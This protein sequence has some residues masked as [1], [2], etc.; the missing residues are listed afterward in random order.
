[1][2]ADTTAAPRAPVRKK[3]FDGAERGRLRAA[4]LRYMEAH[5]IGVPTL[6]V[7][8]AESANRSQDLIPLKTL[9]RF[10]AGT[11]RTNDAILVPCHQFASAL[12]DYGGAEE[13]GPDM[14]SRALREFFSLPEPG[15]LMT[16]VLSNAYAVFTNPGGAGLRQFR[17]DD[18]T[19]EVPYSEFALPAAPEGPC[20]PVKEQVFNPARRHP[21]RPDDGRVC[22]RYEGVLVHFGNEIFVLLKNVLTRLPKTY[23]LWRNE[24]LLEGFRFEPP[25][26]PGSDVTR[27]PERFVF[28]PRRQ[29]SSAS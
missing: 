4:L 16:P 25:F 24:R 19:F 3:S 13:G 26:T 7:R 15:T 20:L 22:H 21:F 28:R 23:G 1:M 6:L 2:A 10:L 11:H 18:V 27:T 17:R 8:I 9:Q 14:L 12:P 29:E 5:R